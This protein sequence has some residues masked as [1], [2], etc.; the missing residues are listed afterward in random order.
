MDSTS[1][2]G[3][4][5]M[6]QKESNKFYRNAYFHSTKEIMQLLSNARFGDFSF[7]QTLIK[8]EENS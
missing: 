6:Q 3:E 2:L 7:W 1:E 5:Y 4:R 8:P